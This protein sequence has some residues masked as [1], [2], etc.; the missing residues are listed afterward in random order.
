MHN[1]EWNVVYFLNLDAFLKI[2]A[3]GIVKIDPT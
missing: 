2:V 1:L 3:V